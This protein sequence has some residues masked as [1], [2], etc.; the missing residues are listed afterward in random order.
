[1]IFN[2]KCNE[3]NILSLI[4]NKKEMRITTAE[5]ANSNIKQ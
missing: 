4:N 1:M 2:N 3:N 5:S